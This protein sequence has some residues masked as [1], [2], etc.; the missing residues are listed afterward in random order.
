MVNDDRKKRKVK[1]RPVTKIFELINFGG[2]SYISPAFKEIC[3]KKFSYSISFKKKTQKGKNFHL[4]K[5]LLE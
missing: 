2:T 5:T 1:A 3:R 4:P